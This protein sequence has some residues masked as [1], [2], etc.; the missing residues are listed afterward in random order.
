MIISV[1]MSALPFTYSLNN[2]L[3]T[4]SGQPEALSHAR[5]TG[6]WEPQRAIN[7]ANSCHHPYLHFSHK[8]P[9]LKV[10]Y[11]FVGFFTTLLRYNE[12]TKNCIYLTWFP[13][14]GHI[15]THMIPSPPSRRYHPTPPKLSSCPFV[16][17]SVFVFVFSRDN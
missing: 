11:G 3:S 14:F 16:S 6:R 15:P 17:V 1:H 12:Y 5:S 13:D 7:V 2:L 4:Y 8:N 9:W 10:L